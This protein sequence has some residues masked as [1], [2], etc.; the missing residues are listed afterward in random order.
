MK[1][2]NGRMFINSIL[3][4]TA[5]W[6]FKKVYSMGYAAG[7]KDQR[8]RDYCQRKMDAIF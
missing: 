2:M 4:G 8:F 1:A 6:L 7:E 3:L 5:Y